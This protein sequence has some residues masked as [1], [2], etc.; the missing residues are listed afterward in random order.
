[1]DS[2]RSITREIKIQQW[3]GIFQAKQN[4]SL[5]VDEFCKENGISHHAYYYWLRIVR[6]SIIEGM[7]PAGQ[8]IIEVPP[9]AMSLPED[10]ATASPSEPRETGNSFLIVEKNGFHV[11]V[12]EET[13]VSLLT[14]TLEAIKHV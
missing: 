5:S 3:K 11:S 9:A 13:S 2:I 12:T 14:K 10:T 1:M 7:P 6:E 4:S 8:Q